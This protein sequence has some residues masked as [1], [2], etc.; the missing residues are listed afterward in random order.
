MMFEAV[1]NRAGVTYRAPTTNIFAREV[2][3]TYR[4]GVT[5]RAPTTNI[6]AR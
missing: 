3:V 4:A 1:T 5:Y 2:T 6:F